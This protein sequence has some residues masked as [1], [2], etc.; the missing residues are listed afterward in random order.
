M[1]TVKSKRKGQPFVHRNV[2]NINPEKGIA[3]DWKGKQQK[4]M[5]KVAFTQTW[6]EMFLSS[7][8]LYFFLN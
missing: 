1:P 7:L 4:N 2:V 8:F 5:I 3:I 6:D